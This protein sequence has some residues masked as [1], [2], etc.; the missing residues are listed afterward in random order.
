MAIGRLLF[1]F[2]VALA[3]T[4]LGAAV[5]AAADET[6]RAIGTPPAVLETQSKYDQTDASRSRLSFARA[7]TRDEIL[8]PVRSALRAL[9]AETDACVVQTLRNWAATDALADMRSEDAFLTR[10]RFVAEIVMRLIDAEAAGVLTAGDRAALS[11][12]LSGIAATTIEFYTYRAGP[13][14]RRNNHRYWAGLSVGAIGYLL[15]NAAFRAWGDRSFEIG[16]CQVDARGLLPLELNRGNQALN[17]HIYA[18]RPLLVYD[19]LASRHGHMPGTTC[20]DGLERLIDSTRS[21][22]LDRGGFGLI[23]GK[24]QADFASEASFSGRFHLSTLG[25]AL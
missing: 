12:W 16:I 7:V 15:D 5:P 17:Y 3:L 23:A 18:L 19:Q 20:R 4:V 9:V 22:I 13:V 11:P 8:Q 2:G 1:G 21:G 14:S 24:A 10:D 6:C 25:L